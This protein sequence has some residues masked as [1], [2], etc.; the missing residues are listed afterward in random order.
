MICDRFSQKVDKT[1]KNSVQNTKHTLGN[2]Y[3]KTQFISNFIDTRINNYFTK[4]E[5]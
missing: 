4:L 1:N 3:N 5:P 2:K